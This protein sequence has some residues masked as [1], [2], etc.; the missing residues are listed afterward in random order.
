MQA[1]CDVVLQY[2]LLFVRPTLVAA[3]QQAANQR[4]VVDQVT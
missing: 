3:A 1:E 2:Q 4:R